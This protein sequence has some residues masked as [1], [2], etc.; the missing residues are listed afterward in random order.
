MQ[1]TFL[2]ILG[3]I[4]GSGF[5]QSATKVVTDIDALTKDIAELG[6]LVNATS[7]RQALDDQEVSS[8]DYTEQNNRILSPDTIPTHADCFPYPISQLMNRTQDHP[9]QI[10]QHHP[11]RDHPGQPKGPSRRPPERSVT[12]HGKRAE[13]DMR[14]RRRSTS[15]FLALY[16]TPPSPICAEALVDSP[17][18]TPISCQFWADEILKSPPSNTPCSW[19]P[20]FPRTLS[21]KSR[22]PACMT[23]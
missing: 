16:S 8:T 1:Y 5:A 6:V 21:S 18:P 7:S 11:S 10:R 20:L 14:L 4:A 13:G 19:R 17:P 22:F 3:A 9:E 15:H 12:V 2:F 23:S